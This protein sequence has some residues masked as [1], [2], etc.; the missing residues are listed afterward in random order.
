MP[1]NLWETLK[2]KCSQEYIDSVKKTTDTYV[3]TLL[4]LTSSSETRPPSH[5]RAA[6]NRFRRDIRRITT[7]FF[8]GVSFVMG[9]RRI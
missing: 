9:I 2:A 7:P 5:F 1:P 4:I 8:E 3:Q 6:D